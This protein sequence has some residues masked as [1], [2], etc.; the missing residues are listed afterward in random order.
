MDLSTGELKK[1]DQI[2]SVAR[3]LKILN[4]LG[5][6]NGEMALADIS[7]QLGLAKSTVHGLLS[8]LRDFNYVEQSSF[9]GKYKLGISLF[10]LG[11]VV[12]RNWDLRTVAIPYIQKLLEETELTVHL[13]ILDHG[14]VLYIDKREY[15]DVSLRIVS[16]VG[17][18]LPAHC[19]GVG[20]VLLAYLS[21]NEVKRIITQKGLPLYTDNTISDLETLEKELAAIRQRGYALDR[22]EL[23]NSL[24]CVAAPIRNHEGNVIASISVSMHLSRLV[25]EKLDEVVAKVTE[26]AKAISRGLGFRAG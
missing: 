5:N 7:N 22:E 16:Q 23:M 2:R 17:M 3:A 15:K 11:N 12:A 24:G 19:T 25:G 10:E 14:E 13:A 20:K 6:A 9:T 4:L 21:K 18:R 8:T 26:T 1:S